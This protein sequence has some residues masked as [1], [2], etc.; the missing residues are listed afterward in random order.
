MRIYTSGERDGE[1]QERDLGLQERDGEHR[2]R[3]L[4]LQERPQMIDKEAEDAAD[5]PDALLYSFNGSKEKEQVLRHSLS[6]SA[7]A[8]R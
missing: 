7:T 6:Q 1:H 4:R 8:G 3:D 2:E 5:E